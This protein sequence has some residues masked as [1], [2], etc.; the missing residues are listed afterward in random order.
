[1]LLVHTDQVTVVRKEIGFSKRQRKLLNFLIKDNA[2]WCILRTGVLFSL[3]TH[4]WHLTWNYKIATN[5]IGNIVF[6]DTDYCVSNIST[7]MSFSSIK[8][9][10]HG[11]R[12]AGAT[13]IIHAYKVSFGQW[14][15]LWIDCPPVMKH[16]GK[17]NHFLTFRISFSILF[18]VILY[19]WCDYWHTHTH[20]QYLVIQHIS[21]HI[22]V[23][24]MHTCNGQIN[25]C[26]Q[27]CNIFCAH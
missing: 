2:H 3:Y 26:L 22:E 4:I 12:T 16:S 8:N 14:D 6:T 9:I 11:I 5:F 17:M 18:I 27:N 21:S 7:E 20:T 1:M 25:N 13:I 10:I 23:Y 24:C 15:I 19:I